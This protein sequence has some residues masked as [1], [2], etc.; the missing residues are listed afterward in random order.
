[1][2]ASVSAKPSHWMLVISSR[3]S[4]WRVTDSITLPKMNPTPMPGPI[5]PRP[6]PT[7]SAI[8]FPAFALSALPPLDEPP[9]AWASTSGR[10]VCSDMRTPLS[11]SLGG[12]T[13]EVDRSERGE[14]ERL[15][16]GHDDELEEE[17]RDGHDRGQRADPGGAEQNDHA[18]A[19]E[20]D[21]QVA[22]EH[23]REQSHRER[24]DPDE[25]RD[26]LDHEQ[27]HRR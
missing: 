1:M 4:G 5:V 2:I 3:I 21:Q 25:V 27:G 14:D 26:R 22:G 24:D 10:T 13:A 18:A 7:P 8:A 20:Q 15:Q 23:V 19:H 16:A 12:R 17:E 11:V 6:A 9:L